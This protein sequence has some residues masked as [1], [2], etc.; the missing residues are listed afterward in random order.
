M[1]EQFNST[2]LSNNF[3]MKSRRTT[4]RKEKTSIVGLFFSTL[5]ENE[6]TGCRARHQF[7]NLNPLK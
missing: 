4:M 6:G 5:N 3:K 7:Y 2:Q 1:T